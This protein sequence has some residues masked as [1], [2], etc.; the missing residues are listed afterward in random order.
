MRRGFREFF[1]ASAKSV[2]LQE[3]LFRRGSAIPHIA[4]GLAV[5]TTFRRAARWVGNVPSPGIGYNLI[6]A[7]P[8]PPPSV[9]KAFFH[10]GPFR[11]S[12]QLFEHQH[13]EGL[14]SLLANRRFFR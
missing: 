8:V 7:R 10:A 3:D 4:A 11:P 9:G 1:V 12:N 5:S 6:L 14:R 2:S 13:K